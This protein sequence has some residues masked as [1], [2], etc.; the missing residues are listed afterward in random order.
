MSTNLILILEI[1]HYIIMLYILFGGIGA[2]INK[3]K[4]FLYYHAIFV[5]IILL[6]W[7][8]NNNQ[9]ILSQTIAKLKNTEEERLSSA[10]D[11]VYYNIMYSVI[12]LTIIVLYFKILD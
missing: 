5:L 4:D 11:R 12:L 3:K 9:C 2:I 8:N 10:T 6:H 7:N 1:I